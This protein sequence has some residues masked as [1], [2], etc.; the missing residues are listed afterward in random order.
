[1]FKPKR[2]L[3]NVN[4]QGYKLSGTSL[5][6]I[7][8][9]LPCPVSEV[10]LKE[11]EFSYQKMRAH[12]LHNHLHFDPNHHLSSVYWCA[13]NGS[14]MKVILEGTSVQMETVLQLTAPT[15][16]T[17]RMSNV[18]INFLTDSMG[19][20]CAGGTEIDLFSREFQNRSEKWNIL[21]SFVVSENNPVCLVTAL[22]DTMSPETTDTRADILCAE[23]SSSSSAGRD[24]EVGVATYK[25]V[26]AVFKVNPQ[27]NRPAV[28]D[29]VEMMV[30][31]S[32]R[33]KSLAL[34]AA[35]Q[36]LPSCGETQL[37]LVGETEPIVE[38][39]SSE[40]GSLADTG[41]LSSAESHQGLGFQSNKAY[42]WTQT[43]TDVEIVFELDADIGKRDICC[44]IEPG[45]L[46]V[47]LT[48][49]TTLLTGELMHSVDPTT[50]SWT[51]G[52]SK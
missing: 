37:L 20:I 30:L 10:Q 19:V 17:Q 31:G 5:E 14:V 11:N 12:S 36:C 42:T 50:S 52:N 2:G 28:E 46:V 41:L 29:I 3:L 33:S 40:R 25:W 7:E 49:G 4:F 47:G 23:I 35:F 45:E 32:F 27:L 21:K 39:S 1:M 6:I 44:R 9:D 34:Y 22:V 38:P 24:S 13:S 16:T 48:D 8:E 18:T 26:R 15:T 51:I 43:E